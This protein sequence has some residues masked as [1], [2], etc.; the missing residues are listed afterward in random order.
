MVFASFYFTL[1]L[2]FFS[3]FTGLSEK[4]KEIVLEIKNGQYYCPLIL[5]FS[6]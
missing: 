6:D 1:F 3:K 2:R 4:Y 5:V